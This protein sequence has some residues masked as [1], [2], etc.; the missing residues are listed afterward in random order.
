MVHCFHL[1]FLH[2]PLKASGGVFEP[3]DDIYRL[4]MQLPLIGLC[5]AFEYQ[6]DLLIHLAHFYKG[7][8]TGNVLPFSPSHLHKYFLLDD[9]FPLKK[10]RWT[11]CFCCWFSKW[12]NTMVYTVKYISKYKYYIN[13]PGCLLVA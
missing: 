5:Q 12:K 1:R 13:S 9:Y 6:A 7:P 11:D 2:W 3:G 8:D 4:Y 10:N